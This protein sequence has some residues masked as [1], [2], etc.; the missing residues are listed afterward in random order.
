M[1][2]KFNRIDE[3]RKDSIL[4]TDGEVSLNEISNQVII[5]P[6]CYPLVTPEQI[7]DYIHSFLLGI[8]VQKVVMDNRIVGDSVV[9]QGY[10]AIIAYQLF[11]SNRFTLLNS[12]ILPELA[13]VTWDELPIVYQQV[14]KRFKVQYAIVH[15]DIFWGII[16]RNWLQTT[17]KGWLQAIPKNT[18]N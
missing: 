15:D 6:S 5:P 10:A 17:P 18:A 16:K 9:Q 4:A 11:A 1:T 12:G 14:I 3:L 2:A 7:N 13:G 8:P